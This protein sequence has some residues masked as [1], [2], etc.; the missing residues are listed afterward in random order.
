MTKKNKF[1]GNDSR[2]G[3]ESMGTPAR[4]ASIE[5]RIAKDIASDLADMKELLVNLTI[6]L[7]F[8]YDDLALNRHVIMGILG[9][10]VFVQEKLADELDIIHEQLDTI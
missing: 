5:S 2:A 9:V 3:L 4:R 7:R 6:L 1:K 8:G 10:G